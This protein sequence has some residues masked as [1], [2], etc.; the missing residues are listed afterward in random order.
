TGNRSVHATF[1]LALEH[2]FQPHWDA[3]SPDAPLRHWL[4]IAPDGSAPLTE[5][6]LRIDETILH[7]IAG[8]AGSDPDLAGIAVP[9]PTTHRDASGPRALV[10]SVAEAIG[11]RGRRTIACLNDE[12]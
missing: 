12:T 4:L 9:V 3:L 10:K 11:Q 1:G 5:A 6:A 7:F 8:I 2:L